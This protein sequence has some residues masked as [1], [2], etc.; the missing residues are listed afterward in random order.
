MRRPQTIRA[1][2]LA[3]K[4]AALPGSSVT[5]RLR[6]ILF[7]VSLTCPAKLCSCWSGRFTNRSRADCPDCHRVG[8]FQL[9]GSPDDISGC[10]QSMR[11]GP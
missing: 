2:V 7:R 6:Q 3:T 8:V 4:D 9:P 5:G 11:I 10:A 1:A